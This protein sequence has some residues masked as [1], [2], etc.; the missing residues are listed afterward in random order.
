M[1]L[2]LDFVRSQ[3]P[4]LRDE[5]VFLD[6]AGGSMTLARVAERVQDYLLHT[7]VQLGATYPTSVRAAKR[8][9]S[10]RMRMAEF[11][12]AA[13]PDEI[14]FGPS[15]TILLKILSSAMRSVVGE[16]DELVVTRMDHEANIGCWI[17]LAEQRGA[18]VRF[19]EPDEATGDLE[20]SGLEPLLSDRTRLVA[21]THVSN[22]RGTIH[23]IAEIAREV[24]EHGA[25]ICVDGVAFAPHRPLDVGVWDVDY[26]VFSLY[27]VFGPHHAILYGKHDALLEL[28]PVNHYFFQR[29]HVPGKLEPGNA[30]Y[31]LSHGAAGIVDYVEELG[32][33]TDPSTDP[34]AAR[35]IAWDGI[36]E[37]E[38]TLADRLLSFL[39]SRD[40]VTIVGHADA[41]RERRV[42]TV[43]FVH[44]TLRSSEIVTA[45]D[46]YGI[47][48]RFGHFYAAR[49]IESLDLVAKD[50]VVRVSMVHYNSLAEIDRLVTAFA[51][52]LA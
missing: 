1:P 42:P 34:V 21:V 8:Y 18:V 5:E 24:H 16:G 35:R 14:V 45:M 11:I 2:D 48:I 9:S 33:R 17:E 50:G 49:L 41:A 28:D 4:G 23:P 47:G 3:F 36:S 10:A 29:E 12:G 37:H 7:D 15:S 22:I 26:Y 51:E 44:A 25:R 27:K 13:R 43:S 46:A 32:R 39:R 31:E 30:N 52:I 40:D 38:E 20:L 19:W 6:N